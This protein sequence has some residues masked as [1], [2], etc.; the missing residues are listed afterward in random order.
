LGSIITL[1]P[2]SLIAVAVASTSSLARYSVQAVGMPG[3][4]GPRPAASDPPLVAIE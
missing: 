1:P 4:A 2:C 3:C